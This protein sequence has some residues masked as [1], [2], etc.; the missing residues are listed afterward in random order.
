M[1]RKRGVGCF[2][3]RS[4]HP[5]IR[6]GI[7][8]SKGMQFQLQ[9]F[10]QPMPE[11]SELNAKFAEIVVSEEQLNFW[12]LLPFTLDIWSSFNFTSISFLWH[13]AEAVANA[14]EWICCYFLHVLED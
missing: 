14:Q 1:P 13:I 12:F 8:H 2:G 4:N 6:Y 9:E 7:D 3:S 10:S 5:E 11:E